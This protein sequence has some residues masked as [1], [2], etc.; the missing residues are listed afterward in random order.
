MF[1]TNQL[2]YKVIDIRLYTQADSIFFLKK[3][4]IFKETLDNTEKK[5]KKVYIW[6]AYTFLKS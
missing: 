5:C 3:P 6:F 1:Y 4:E 2:F